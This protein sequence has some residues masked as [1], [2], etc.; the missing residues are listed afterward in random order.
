MIKTETKVAKELVGKE[1]I[2]IGYYRMALKD[3]N[4]QDKAATIDHVGKATKD[5]TKG[6]SIGASAASQKIVSNIINPFAK[7]QSKSEDNKN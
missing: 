3:K 5:L 1:T 2:E 7:I 4:D 6:I